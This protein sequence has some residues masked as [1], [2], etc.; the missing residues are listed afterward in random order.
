MALL[1]HC[2]RDLHQCEADFRQVNQNLQMK[3]KVL[4][5]GELVG[6]ISDVTLKSNF[7]IQLKNTGSVMVQIASRNACVTLYNIVALFSSRK[8][9]PLARVSLARVT[10]PS[11]CTFL[12][13]FF[14][15][16]LQGS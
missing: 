13:F 11:T 2:L 4:S 15:S 12:L 9:N 5:L 3:S 14:P 8:G 6:N 7:K 10:L 1:G 16:C